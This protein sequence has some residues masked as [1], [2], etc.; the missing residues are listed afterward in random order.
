MTWM[1]KFFIIFIFHRQLFLVKIITCIWL[2][3]LT[4]KCI[5]MKQLC[6]LKN[7]ELVFVTSTKRVDFAKRKAFKSDFAV[8]LHSRFIRRYLHSF[9]SLFI[10]GLPI[11]PSPFF[12]LRWLVHGEFKPGFGNQP[13]GQIRGKFESE[14]SLDNSQ[15]KI[16]LV[17][18]NSLLLVEQSKVPDCELRS[19]ATGSITIHGNS[20]STPDCKKICTITIGQSNNDNW[21]NKMSIAGLL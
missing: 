1:V 7:W 6:L 18:C 8:F 20:F 15:S 4:K 14:L 9:F 2:V 3:L 10:P 16:Q 19:L 11:K 13:C 12:I 17:P 5:F 21:D